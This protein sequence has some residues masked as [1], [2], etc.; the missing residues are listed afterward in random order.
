MPDHHACI[1]QL[2]PVNEAHSAA[3]PV[4]SIQLHIVL[5]AGQ[6]SRAVTLLAQPRK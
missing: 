2:L 5:H 4:R 3:Q 1:T 6:R